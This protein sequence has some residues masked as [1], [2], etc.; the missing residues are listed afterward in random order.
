MVG[1]PRQSA[2]SG[3]LGPR[4]LQA[5]IPVGRPAGSC[6]APF[7]MLLKTALFCWQSLGPSKGL[8]YTV[9]GLCRF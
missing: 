7:R 6:N 8:L 1:S 4:P 5:P 9:S 3:N 2:R